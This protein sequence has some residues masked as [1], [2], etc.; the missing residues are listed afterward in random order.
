MSLELSMTSVFFVLSS[1]CGFNSLSID[2]LGNWYMPS[3]VGGS[4]VK[5][6]GTAGRFLD[7]PLS[8]N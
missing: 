2:E 3:E 5:I 4:T 7:N 6:K 8:Q 1:Y